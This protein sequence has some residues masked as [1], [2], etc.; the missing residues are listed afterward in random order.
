[1]LSWRRY[2]NACVGFD[3]GS[4]IELSSLLPMDENLECL[5]ATRKLYSGR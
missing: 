1:M 5:E 4:D 2:G 3:N